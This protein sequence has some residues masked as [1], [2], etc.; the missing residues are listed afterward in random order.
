MSIKDWFIKRAI[1][2]LIKK[3]EKENNAMWKWLEGKK[4]YMVMAV[5]LI[6]GAIEAGQ[7][8]GIITWQIPGLVFTI[9]GALGWYTRSVAKPKKKTTKKK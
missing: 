9:L 8:A 5:T 7:Q 6:L 1:K 3:L 4:T 2:N